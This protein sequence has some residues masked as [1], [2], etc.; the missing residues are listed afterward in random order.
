[1]SSIDRFI[2]LFS[3]SAFF[4]IGAFSLIN[5]K[6]SRVSHNNS[7]M[8][9]VTAAEMA[10]QDPKRRAI[11]SLILCYSEEKFQ[12][13]LKKHKSDRLFLANGTTDGGENLEI[14]ASNIL[15]YGGE[16]S[17][18]IHR[19]NDEGST[20]ICRILHGKN[21]ELKDI[22]Q[23]KEKLSSMEEASDEGESEEKEEAGTSRFFKK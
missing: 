1:M 21:L 5:Y 16:F 3:L 14:R 2:L 10:A 9:S 7:V 11:E 12:E 18:Y 13:H 19:E 15:G 23:G 22:S 20:E 8:V 6:L 4:F 17:V